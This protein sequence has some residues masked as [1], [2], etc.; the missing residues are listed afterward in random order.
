MLDEFICRHINQY[1]CYG[2]VINFYIFTFSHHNQ[3]DC[4][5]ELIT[6]HITHRNWNS[7]QYYRQYAFY[8]RFCYCY[9]YYKYI[10]KTDSSLAR[11]FFCECQKK[12]IPVIWA[13]LNCLC[14]LEMS[15]L[16]WFIRFFFKITFKS[17][18]KRT[19]NVWRYT[20]Y[21]WRISSSEYKYAYLHVVSD[22]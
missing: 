2:R 9:Y 20:L 22:G 11:C 16:M 17:I 18:L 14:I 8:D 12:T 3:T 13:V 15:T 1:I 4:L 21:R 19:C 10:I 5:Y 7:V 6:F